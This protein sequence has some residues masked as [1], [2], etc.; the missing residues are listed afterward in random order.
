M[1]DQLWVWSAGNE[2]AGSSLRLR[3]S[4]SQRVRVSMRQ[5]GHRGELFR[6]D[7]LLWSGWAHWGICPLH[8]VLVGAPSGGQKSG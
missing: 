6:L 8:A 4:S 2:D 3:C 7:P 1:S 5:A